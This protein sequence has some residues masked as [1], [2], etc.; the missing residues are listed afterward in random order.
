MSPAGYLVAVL[1]APLAGPLLYR[2]L[3]DRPDAVRL[4]DGFVYVAVPVLVALQVL[5]SAWE[6]RSALVVT[7]FSSR[8]EIHGGL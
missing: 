2:L 8:Q 6:H 3:H 5:P 4:V 1:A 7:S